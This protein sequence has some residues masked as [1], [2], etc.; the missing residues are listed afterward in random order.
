MALIQGMENAN[1]TV[2]HFGWRVNGGLNRPSGRSLEYLQRGRAARIVRT[3]RNILCGPVVAAPSMGTKPYRACQCHVEHPTERA[4]RESASARP[5]AGHICRRSRAYSGGASPTLE[6]TDR[7]RAN[8]SD[9]VVLEGDRLYSYGISWVLPSDS[10]GHAA[11]NCFSLSRR[12]WEAAFNSLPIPRCFRI[13]SP[14]NP[15]APERMSQL[16]H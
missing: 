14:T 1:K 9:I 11:G 13:G 15:T 2:S 8:D 16:S 3:S 4:G 5:D 10:K 7:C 12:D 6:Q